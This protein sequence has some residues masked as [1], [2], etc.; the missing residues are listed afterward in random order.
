MDKAKIR[1]YTLSKPRC[2]Y[3]DKEI[4]FNLQ[5]TLG[6]LI[7]LALNP[8]S[9]RRKQ[10][11]G[12]FWDYF[13]T[14]K[15]LAN[16]SRHLYSLKQIFSE[17][18]SLLIIHKDKIERKPTNLI[19]IDVLEFE[20][21]VKELKK[22]PKNEKIINEILKIYQE[23]FLEEF[24]LSSAN[25]F[26]E[27]AYFKREEIKQNF[28]KILNSY[29]ENK[30]VE[31]KIEVAVELAKKSLKTDGLQEPIYQKLML[32]YYNLGKKEPALE[33]YKLC[34][35]RLKEE[36]NVSPSPETT[37][38]YQQMLKKESLIK[39]D[40]KPA[41]VK[42][43]LPHESQRLL[44]VGRD[45]K[46]KILLN[47]FENLKNLEKNAIFINGEA[48]IGKT[49][50]VLEFLEKIKD[51]AYVVY[52]K[53]YEN[54]KLLGYYPIISAWR[55]FFTSMDYRIPLEVVYLRDLL[56]FFPELE[57]HFGISSAP[58]ANYPELRT[59]LFESFYKL[60]LVYGVDYPVIFF[61]DDLACCD[62]SS[63]ELLHYLACKL[64]GQNFLLICN[65]RT[66]NLQL[67]SKFRDYVN[68][69]KRDK[70]CH[71]LEVE[72]IKELDLL[73]IIK[74]EGRYL[75]DFIHDVFK[76]SGGIP[77]YFTEILNNLVQEEKIKYLENGRIEVPCKL[78]LDIY[79]PAS[80]KESLLILW[81]KMNWNG[82]RLLK[83]AAIIGEQFAARDMSL[84]LEK[85]ESDT[86]SLLD[87]LVCKNIFKKNERDYKVYYTF[88]HDKIEEFIY[89]R[90]LKD[91]SMLLHR[92]IAEFFEKHYKENNLFLGK[93][94][95]HY[96][97][98]GKHSLALQYFIRAGKYF[99]GG[100]AH[101]EA[102]QNYLKAY[103]LAQDVALKIEIL[104]GL[105]ALYAKI[106]KYDRAL[107]FY[108][109]GIILAEKD[110]ILKVKLQILKAPVYYYF[111]KLNLYGKCYEKTKKLLK[112]NKGLIDRQQYIDYDS[113]IDCGLI[114]YQSSA[115]KLPLA[116]KTCLNVL[117]ILKGA[118]IENKNKTKAKILCYLG[119]INLQ[120]AKLNKS[121]EYFL[122][123][124]KLLKKDNNFY[125]QAL[126]YRLLGVLCYLQENYQKAREFSKLELKVL[127][128][129]KADSFTA[130]AYCFLG[131]ICL[132]LKD[133][134]KV[135]YYLD[136]SSQLL[137][138]ESDF[139]ILSYM[140][141]LFVEYNLAIKNLHEAKRHFENYLKLLAETK[142]I[143]NKYDS[144]YLKG[145]IL[146]YESKNYKKVKELYLKAANFFR[147]NGVYVDL[148][149]VLYE[150]MLLSKRKDDI[151]NFEKYKKE[152]LK[153]YKIM[154]NKKKIKLI[155]NMVY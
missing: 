111:G 22:S 49:R 93:I 36:L 115:L 26:N 124:L 7:Y 54:Q 134:Q 59:R 29:L 43:T 147:K 17:I 85:N 140:E 87:D 122:K 31:K 135:K 58:F 4:N 35:R 81:Q 9:H 39:N 44:L 129:L 108:D 37:S 14:S 131:W 99:Q 155:K 138:E 67:N 23:N 50:I 76:K 92:Y 21:L 96:L 20:N 117:N 94:A 106:G 5:K 80:L 145:K 126:V 52:S 120:R 66:E 30:L 100:L 91:E 104:T 110:P 154:E 77:L 98:A 48:G 112:K 78:P 70:L 42:F 15:S 40:L 75:K 95:Y 84:L 130:G 133:F 136:K 13:E 141:K 51:K 149:P 1:I 82:Q 32:A 8:G 57:E 79:L 109:E 90:I 47:S 105:G 12:L 102:I 64:K 27:W 24:Y 127:E 60:I 148:V 2:L 6:L 144:F 63:M 41:K 88:L 132:N 33:Q 151:K 18:E 86:C 45:E 121:K 38:I 72:R 101:E 83:Y 25:I 19:W 3:K 137:K 152:A 62:E 125:E 73:G 16:L 28:L 89:E 150:L 116:E 11:A 74:G 143:S 68:N 142:F 69:F 114:F 119:R 107:K 71:V 153:I 55:N 46:L 61:I 139:F 113:T 123:G 146:F 118:K 53:C 65:F 34:K 103:E 10:L 97:K 128:N 56:A